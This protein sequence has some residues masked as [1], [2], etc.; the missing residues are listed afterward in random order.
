M[1]EQRREQ[2]SNAVSFSYVTQFSR[3]MF[4][5]RNS[6]AVI[7]CRDRQVYTTGTLERLKYTGAAGAVCLKNNNIIIIRRRRRNYYQGFR[8]VMLL[9]SVEIA[10]GK[11]ISLKL[12]PKF[13]FL[14]N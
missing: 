12:E 5:I 3:R 4:H 8:P 7:I 1:T 13:Q 14:E 2:N 9:P 10:D 6:L 11:K